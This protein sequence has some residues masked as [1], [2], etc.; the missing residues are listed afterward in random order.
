MTA[1]R[2]ESRAVAP[3]RADGI[4]VVRADRTC[5]EWNGIHYRTG[6]S[7]FNT[8]ATALSMNIATIPSGGVAAAH[9]HVGFE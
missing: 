4:T 5:R 3:E 1:M 6:L 8:G 7:G 9:V 2:P